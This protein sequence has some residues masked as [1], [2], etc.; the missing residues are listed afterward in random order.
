VN[1]RTSQLCGYN[2]V[3]LQ[4]INFR[5]LNPTG[6]VSDFPACWQHP[7]KKRQDGKNQQDS[8]VVGS[9]CF[10]GAPVPAE[11]VKY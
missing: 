5:Q 1:E 9:C 8:S 6:E 2:K 3:E 10:D 7:V 11:V 4:N